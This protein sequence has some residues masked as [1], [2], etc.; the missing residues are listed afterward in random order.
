MDLS[1][2][3]AIARLQEDNWWYAARR[4]LVDRLL[5]SRA[6]FESGL[7]LG[8][9][10]GGNLQLL[11]AHCKRW[12]GIDPSAEA[13]QWCRERWCGDEESDAVVVGDA[14]DLDLANDSFDLV[15]CLDVLEHLDDVAAVTEIHRVL[16][17]GGLLVVTVPAHSYLWN[18]NDDFSQHLRRYDRKRLVS[19][20]SGFEDLDVSYWNFTSFVPML[21][22]A[23]LRRIVPSKPRNNL[24]A[25]P[26]LMDRPLA[27]ALGLENR[28]RGFV[29]TPTGTSLVALGRAP[30]ETKA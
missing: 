21:A 24:D 2:Y 14:T 5:S 11:D 1:N 16:R 8:C 12:H 18:E 26:G 20:L 25:V 28:I 6:P 7:D 9:G 3:Y 19:V 23:A 29:P 4:T 10:L 17:P 27:W 22:Y 13:V 15:L 30:A